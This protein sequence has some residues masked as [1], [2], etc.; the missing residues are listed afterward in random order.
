MNK[1]FETNQKKMSLE[2]IQNIINNFLVHVLN[3]NDW[4]SF[5][6][7]FKPK[8]LYYYHAIFIFFM[9]YFLNPKVIINNLNYYSSV[10][11]NFLI[12]IIKKK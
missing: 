4:I 7:F 11:I 10:L 5:N 1:F 9:Q 6:F 12:N 8:N 2:E 3:I